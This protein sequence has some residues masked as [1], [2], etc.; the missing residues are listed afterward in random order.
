MRYNTLT[1]KL[2]PSSITI[3]RVIIAPIFFYSLINNLLIYSLALFLVAILTDAI[4]GYLARKY[5][6]TSSI[7]AYLDVTADFILVLAGFLAFVYMGVYPYW[8]LIIIV[9]MFIQFL[10]T[11][12]FQI[13]IYDPLGKYYGSFLFLMIFINIFS[14]NSFLNL[15]LI[16]ILV[17][18]SFLS[19]IIRFLSIFIYKNRMLKK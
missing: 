19:I 18:Y 9:F 17:S 5:N 10:V 2:I 15:I 6:A 7:G 3:L 8:I 1:I 16:I 4:D 11:S 13:L 14:T 12:K